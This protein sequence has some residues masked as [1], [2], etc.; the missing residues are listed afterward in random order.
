MLQAWTDF[1][2]TAIKEGKI[3]DIPK[4]TLI[5]DIPTYPNGMDPNSPEVCS[6]IGRECRIGGD[7]WDAPTGQVALSFDD[8]PTPVSGLCFILNTVLHLFG[9]NAI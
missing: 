7:H 3:P 5:N 8:G 4:T 1:L 9:H 2:E 6:A